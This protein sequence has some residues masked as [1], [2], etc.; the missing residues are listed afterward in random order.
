M[1]PRHVAQEEKALVERLRESAMSLRAQVERAD[2]FRIHELGR[3]SE[4]GAKV[5]S[6]PDG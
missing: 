2:D 6:A 4:P 1:V 5:S 3:R